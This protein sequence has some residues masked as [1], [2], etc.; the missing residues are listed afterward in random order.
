[1]K[2][3]SHP[4][5]CS[6]LGRDR[7]LSRTS[8]CILPLSQGRAG[9]Y[10]IFN[11]IWHEKLKVLQPVSWWP[12]SLHVPQVGNTRMD[13]DWEDL[14]WEDRMKLSLGLISGQYFP[15]VRSNRLRNASGKTEAEMLLRMVPVWVFKKKKPT[16]CLWPYKGLYYAIRNEQAL[17][18]QCGPVRPRLSWL[19]WEPL[20]SGAACLPVWA[21]NYM[22]V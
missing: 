9:S 18:W 1:M 12:S 10:Q 5:L 2:S 4:A 22:L 20:A 21:A 13:I 17:P 3:L 8:Y 7:T 19:W 16:P 15:A 6:A 14:T 11:L